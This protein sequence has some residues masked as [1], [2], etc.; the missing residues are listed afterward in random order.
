MAG[1][2]LPAHRPPSL[3]GKGGE[4]EMAPAIRSIGP[5]RPRC[6]LRA[7]NLVS[8]PVAASQALGFIHQRLVT[9]EASPAAARL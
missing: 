6:S 5:A 7:E 8:K 4:G 9:V 3:Q 2:H 1:R